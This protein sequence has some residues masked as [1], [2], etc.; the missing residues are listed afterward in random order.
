MKK[1]NMLLKK[2]GDLK[3]DIYPPDRKIKKR[4][5]GAQNKGLLLRGRICNKLG[6]E[7]LLFTGD[8][9]HNSFG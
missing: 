1:R 9:C 5:P 3:N 2:G 8:K 7:H 4:R 6:G